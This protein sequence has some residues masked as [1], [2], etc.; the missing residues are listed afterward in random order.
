[1]EE[2]FGIP[3]RHVPV[4]VGRSD[5]PEDYGASAAA[6]P[7]GLFFA[8]RSPS[9]NDVAHEVVHLLQHAGRGSPPHGVGAPGTPA[10]READSLAAAAELGATGLHARVGAVPTGSVQLKRT[11]MDLARARVQAEREYHQ[12]TQEFEAKLGPHLSKRPEAIEIA[13]GLLERLKKVVDAWAESTRQGTTEVYGTDFSFPT[14]EKYYGSFKTTGENIKQVFR[15]KDQPLRKKLNVIYYAVRNN[16]IAKYLEAAAIE[17]VRAQEALAVNPL[18]QF[19]V[20]VAQ[21]GQAPA[22]HIVRAG[23]AK[24][25]GL[26]RYLGAV[27]AGNKGPGELTAGEIDAIVTRRQKARAR[28]VLGERSGAFATAPPASGG[29]EDKVY[30]KSEGLGWDEQPTLTRESLGDITA[31]EIRLL[32]E[33]KGKKPS[34]F[35][36]SRKKQKWAG[37]DRM[38]PWEMGVGNIEVLPGSETR[39]I[40]D[41]Y[42]ARL[43]AGISGSTDLMMHTGVHLGLRA[44]AEKKQLR[45][46]LLGW[47]LSNRDH[48]FY[49]IMLAASGYGIPFHLD[50]AQPGA[51]YEHVDNFAPL[52]AGDVQGFAALTTSGN[53]PS[54]YLSQ[55]HLDELAGEARARRKGDGLPKSTASATAAVGADVASLAG[56]DASMLVAHHEALRAAVE[57]ANFVAN[58]VP[59][60]DGLRKNRVAL[61]KLREDPSFHQLALRHPRKAAYAEDALEAEIEAAC[62]GALMPAARLVELGVMHSIAAPAG[63]VGRLDLARLALTVRATGSMTDIESSLAYLGVKRFIS[64]DKRDVVL[65]DLLAKQ[66]NV[67][68]ARADRL[69]RGGAEPAEP[70]RIA[71]R[72]EGEARFFVELGIPRAIWE[73]PLKGGA[74][75][76]D[77]RTDTSATRAAKIR[78]AIEHLRRRILKENFPGAYGAAWQA[79]T[80]GGEFDQLVTAIDA[81]SGASAKRLAKAVAAKLVEAAHG[82]GAN[83]AHADQAT[84]ASALGHRMSP[85]DLARTGRSHAMDTGQ[86]ATPAAFD[87]SA[88]AREKYWRA[89]GAAAK[90][91][92]NVGATLIPALERAMADAAVFLAATNLVLDAQ[93]TQIADRLRALASSGVKNDRDE[94]RR[95]R[96]ALG[97]RVHSPLQVQHVMPQIRAFLAG[98][99]PQA[100]DELAPLIPDILPW[101]DVKQILGPAHPLVADKE[102]VEGLAEREKGALFAY[103]TKL[104]EDLGYGTQLM[105]TGTKASDLRV[106]DPGLARMMRGLD[107]S[108]P[109]IK[110]MHSGLAKLPAYTRGEVFHGTASVPGGIQD[111]LLG[112]DPAAIGQAIE[113]TFKKR[114]VISFAYPFSTATDAA[115]SFLGHG[116]KGL[117]YVV[118]QPIRSGKEI[119][120]LSDKPAEGEV[121]FPQGVRFTVV[122]A[123]TTRPDGSTMPGVNVWVTVREA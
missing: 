71:A 101:G 30:G 57:P 20:D 39:R 88:L 122:H 106:G 118:Q 65:R 107:Y 85:A 17:I 64:R 87:V 86:L 56:P 48:S 82:A 79:S 24:K 51:E 6:T 16:A 98:T 8:D 26:A 123:G 38:V 74:G 25:S 109:L 23:F 77:P 115:R 58:V 42:K 18:Q 59:T 96:A 53:M 114:S 91:T 31:D 120:L 5:L 36:T 81:G 75:R 68:P 21:P 80:T 97:V 94:L 14:G 117:A 66:R 28:P 12:V 11:S 76:Y 43:D 89:Q 110:A 10:E 40:A 103:T 9:R 121:L 111:A 52:G 105:D 45:L 99:V 112:G 119:S 7:T 33:R 27:D 49:E 62:P 41:Q 113:R 60:E 90:F 104:H 29:R 34:R 69:F 108:L 4:E 1:M 92:T 67:S 46:A 55:G 116:N 32:Q 61:Q 73:E 83:L 63:A 93:V 44:D 102:A 2:A 13:D 15:K 70:R 37:K 72:A 19:E 50:A 22:E 3:L 47:M 54:W 84:L 95:L 100:P 35:V 78:L